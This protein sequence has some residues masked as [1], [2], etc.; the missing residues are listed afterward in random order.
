MDLDCSRFVV[1]GA[2]HGDARNLQGVGFSELLF[3]N[4]EES[5]V[6]RSVKKCISN[7]REKQNKKTSPQLHYTEAAAAEKLEMAADRMS[8][9]KLPVCLLLA[10][11]LIYST[12]AFSF[13]RSVI[14][15][16]RV[17]GS[18]SHQMLQ[19]RGLNR[20]NRF[21][22]RSH[23]K[24]QT[25]MSLEI[26]SLASS[27]NIATL[28][29]F[30]DQGS[31]LAGKFFQGSLLPYLGFLFFLKN[32]GKQTP[33]MS[34]FG[35]QFLLLFVLATIPTGIISKSIYGQSLADVDWLH[36]AAESLLTVT[37]LL[38]VSGF[39]DATASGDTSR[40]NAAL[41][42]AAIATA[43]AVAAFAAIGQPVLGLEAHT[44]FLA[45][46]G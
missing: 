43:A 11:V 29:A 18:N 9:S 19:I 39:R 32:S 42:G 26:E 35:F 7:T 46:I 22:D 31:N 38:I 1:R 8:N 13:P 37:N 25:R 17:V 30:A 41:R 33:A 6:R 24:L 21:A 15:Q 10:M 14:T 27:Q 16:R 36:G 20:V 12:D 40:D 44:P 5:F 3:Y 45:G 4:G 28:L 2:S 34:F 23:R